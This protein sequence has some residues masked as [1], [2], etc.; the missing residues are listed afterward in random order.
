MKP[1]PER[2]LGVISEN[3]S[4]H[5]NRFAQQR[6]GFFKEPLITKGRR[7]VARRAA[8]SGD[9]DEGPVRRVDARSWPRSGGCHVPYAVASVV[10]ITSAGAALEP[11]RSR[12]L[13]FARESPHLF[14]LAFSR[15]PFGSTHPSIATTHCLDYWSHVGLILPLRLCFI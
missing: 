10:S 2:G 3:A 7:I 14:P 1:H 8:Q 12:V 9:R 4:R 5:G 6:F 11:Y 13:H 15:V